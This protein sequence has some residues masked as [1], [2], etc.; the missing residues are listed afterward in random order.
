MTRI[1]QARRS[2]ARLQKQG[3][4]CLGETRNAGRAFVAESRIAGS[5]F[6]RDMT[7]ASSK[8]TTAVGRSG[9]RLRRELHK[10]GLHWRDLVLQTREAYAAAVRDR[11]QDMERRAASAREALSPDALQLALLQS[12]AEGLAW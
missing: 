10:E 2:A 5:S 1:N 12:A 11:L 8:L 7:A 9:D 6:A 3:V 4:L